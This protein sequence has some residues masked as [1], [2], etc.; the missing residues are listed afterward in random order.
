VTKSRTDN[1]YQQPGPPGPPLLHV[2]VDAFF[3]AVERRDDPGLSGL[4]LAVVD[5]VVSC[6]SYEARAHGVHAGMRAAEAYRT[7]PTLVAVPS[8]AAAYERASAELFALL[9]GGAAVEAGS[10]EEAFLAVPGLGWPGAA[11]AAGQLRERIGAG[12]SLPV[13]VG[14]GRTKL[15]AKVASR[16]AKPNGIVVI[17]PAEEPAVRRALRIADLWG[18][19]PVTRDRLAEADIG[20]VA[21]LAS[22]TLAELVELAG[23]AMGRRLR[24]IAAGTDDATIRPPA[25]RRSFSVSRATPARRPPEPYLRELAGELAARLHASGHL[26]RTVYIGLRADAG[27]ATART[28]LARHT[29]DA[30]TLAGTVVALAVEL[31]RPVART[32]TITLSD[33]VPA[34]RPGQSPLPGL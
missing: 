23:T 29:A 25:P 10:M 2:D 34:G 3:V 13:S 26:A 22:R 7:C 12:L 17:D 32:V 19:G 4:P 16:R 30:A 8:R 33:L 20:T 14:V 31:G 27:E 11:Q 28:R 21:D 5:R 15:V 9:R 6:A 1:F 24:H 18:I